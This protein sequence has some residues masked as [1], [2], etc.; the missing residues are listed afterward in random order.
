MQRTPHFFIAILLVLSACQMPDQQTDQLLLQSAESLRAAASM[1]A[2]RLEL[3]QARAAEMTETPVMSQIF[4]PWKSRIQR[5]KDFTDTAALQMKLLRN[6]L[7]REQRLSDGNKKVST[8]WLQQ[9]GKLY[10]SLTQFRDSILNVYPPLRNEFHNNLTLFGRSVDSTIQSQDDVIALLT[11]ASYP[12]ALSFLNTVEFNVLNAG[13]KCA[14]YCLESITY[15]RTCDSGPNLI[16]AQNPQVVLPGASV[17]VGFGIGIFPYSNLYKMEVSVKG[18]PS[19]LLE[20]GIESVQWK[21]ENVP[22]NYKIPLVIKYVDQDG[23]RTELL[24][25]IEYRVVDTM[26]I[27]GN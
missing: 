2:Q 17:E 26:R 24:K 23:K 6:Q 21:A 7:Q 22:G 5:I 10:I 11:S 4:A 9:A 3:T 18:G 19:K 14:A 12:A 13:D 8:E 16:L 20:K 27:A 1:M 25:W 15:H